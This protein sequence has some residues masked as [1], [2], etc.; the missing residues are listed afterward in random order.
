MSA[1]SVNARHGGILVGPS[2]SQ[3]LSGGV[4]AIPEDDRTVSVL[5]F[6]PPLPRPHLRAEGDVHGSHL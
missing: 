2:G 3:S 1:P 5:C 6:Q 4:S